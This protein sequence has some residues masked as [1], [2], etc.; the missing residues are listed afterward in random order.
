MARPREKLDEVQ[1]QAPAVLRMLKERQ[2]KAWEKQ[3]LSAVAL[4]IRGD[5]SIPEIAENVGTS[6]SSVSRW[7][8]AYRQGGIKALLTLNRG[9]GPESSLTPAIA[10]D[11]KAALPTMLFRRA[12][13]V[14]VWLKQN[15]D[16]EVSRSSVYNYLKKL[17]RG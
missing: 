10:D 9:N 8:R 2:R 17:K 4:G 6:E 16:L 12:Q 5:L 14:A 11:L 3:R 7:F 15:H 1:R 13:D